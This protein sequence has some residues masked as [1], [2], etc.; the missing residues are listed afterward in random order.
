MANWGLRCLSTQQSAGRRHKTP[1]RC[2]NKPIKRR[3]HLKKYSLLYP[4]ARKFAI[5]LIKITDSACSDLVLDCPGSERALMVFHHF[6]NIPKLIFLAAILSVPC[7]VARPAVAQQTFTDMTSAMGTNESGASYGQ[8]VSWCDMDL[9]GD[10]DLAFSY[11]HG[12][13]LNCLRRAAPGWIFLMQPAGGWPYLGK[14]PLQ[15]AATRLSGMVWMKR[16]FRHLREF[17]SVV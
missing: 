17:I 8:A 6:L 5:I 15:P 2:A 16:A 14:V 10:L 1:S 11:T 13:S 7:M 3:I 12:G 9:D 4:N